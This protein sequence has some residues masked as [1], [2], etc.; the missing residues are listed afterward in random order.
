[1]ALSDIEW[2][3]VTWNPIRGCLEV[4]P[5]CAHCYAKTFAERFRGAYDSSG[6][7]NAYH[8]GFDFRIVP[9]KL[10]EPLQWSKPRVVFSNSM[11][12]LFY[13]EN[14]DNYVAAICDVMRLSSHHLFQ[15]LTKRQD[16]MLELLSGDLRAAAEAP[17][18]WWGVSVENKNRGLPRI[19]A[20]RKSPAKTKFLSVEPLLED[21]GKIDLTGIHWVIV[22]GESGHNFREMKPEWV[23]NIY[24]QCKE[25][26]VH[27]FFKQ[28]GGET[29]KANG[30]LLHGKTYDE[31]PE[32]ITVPISAKERGQRLKQMREVAETFI[33]H[34][35]AFVT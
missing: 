25:Q 13:E 1:M 12:D 18:I 14:P 17:N 7:K 23:E 35:L 28:W 19:D 5:G 3:E 24:Q 2:T 6:R 11:S 20:L 29:P 4:S 27:F 15:V 16:R 30:R 8:Y 10:C 22:G 32:Q 34:P 26:R 31:M 21:L 33:D 9:H